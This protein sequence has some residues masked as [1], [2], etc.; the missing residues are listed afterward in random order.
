MFPFDIGTQRS[1]VA[2]N[3]TFRVSQ[4]PVRV[5][6]KNPADRTVQSDHTPHPVHR[7]KLTG[8][9][10]RCHMVTGTAQREAGTQKTVLKHY[11]HLSGPDLAD[12]GPD[13]VAVC[14]LGAIENHGSHLPLGTDTILADAIL[15]AVDD[16]LPAELPTVRLPALWLG[17]SIEHTR[18]AGTLSSPASRLI[19]SIGDVAKGLSDHGVRRLVLFSAHGGNNPPAKIAAVEARARHGMLCAAVHWLDF[20]LP[21]GLVPPGPVRADTHGGW[22]ETSMMLAVAPD[23]V[24]K[25]RPGPSGKTPPAAMLYPDGPVAWGWM[26]DDLGNDGVIGNPEQA[27]LELGRALVDHAATSLAQLIGQISAAEWNPAPSPRS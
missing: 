1:R 20:G 18:R 5:N 17:A 25:T 9:T 22:M 15:D 19:A 14:P 27:T 3:R 21:E 6:D 23:L 13:T 7:A 8:V 24:G 16:K 26:S 11:A 4:R 2:N 10:I 12:L